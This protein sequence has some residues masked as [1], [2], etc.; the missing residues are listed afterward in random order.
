MGASQAR[1][2]RR[3]RAVAQSLES[4]RPSLPAFALHIAGLME[5]LLR[6]G[7]GGPVRSFSVAHHL[8]HPSTLHTK[9]GHATCQ[10]TN[11]GEFIKIQSRSCKPFFHEHFPLK[12]AHLPECAW[13]SNQKYTS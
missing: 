1:A 6:A 8:Q 4:H 5:R 2:G 7:G 10:R 12:E 3:N 11:V 13:L 9:H